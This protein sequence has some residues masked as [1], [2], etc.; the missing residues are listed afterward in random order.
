MSFGADFEKL[1]LLW[2]K[3]NTRITVSHVIA[4]CKQLL[5]LK[6]FNFPVFVCSTITVN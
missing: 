2:A 4:D 6:P 1:L 5:L 3:R